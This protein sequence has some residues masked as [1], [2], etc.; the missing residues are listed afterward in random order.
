MLFPVVVVTLVGGVAIACGRAS[1]TEPPREVN[2]AASPASAGEV[3][4]T[5]AGEPSTTGSAPPAAAT[6]GSGARAPAPT[7]GNEQPGGGESPTPEADGCADTKCPDDAYCDLKTVVCVRAPCPPIPTCVTGTHPCAATLCMTNS[8]CE[9]HD[10]KAV[11][12]PLAPSGGGVVCGKVM[13]EPGMV[14]CNAS[15]GICTPPDGVCTQQACE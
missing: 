5:G 9:S 6:S 2:A 12:I 11:C 4:V 3:P 8:R 1:P 14:C 10:G 13:C 7:H 15:C